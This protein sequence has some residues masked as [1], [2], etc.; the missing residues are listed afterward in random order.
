MAMFGSGNTTAATGI[1][2]FG[3]IAGAVN[4]PCCFIGAL[5]TPVATNATNGTTF[6]DARPGYQGI[7]DYGQ[8][9]AYGNSLFTPS[10]PNG[11]SGSYTL[12]NGVPANANLVAINKSGTE[13]GIRIKDSRL[14]AAPRGSQRER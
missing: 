5:F 2:S 14:M 11:T 8:T 12:L 3:Q 7:N 13:A 6:S 10:A 9:I 4:S 1:N